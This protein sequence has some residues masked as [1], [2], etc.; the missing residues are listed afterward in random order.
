MDKKELLYIECI[1]AQSL[2][3][4]FETIEEMLRED[5]IDILCIC[6]TWLDS[7]LESKYIHIPKFNVTRSD[8]GRGAGVCI[9]S[10]E[11][12]KI[13][14]LDTGLDKIVNVED[15]WLQ[16]QHK[17]FSSFIVGCVYRHPK[18]LV[19]SFHYISN[20]FKNMCLNNKPIFILG[21]FNDNFFTKGNHLSKICKSLNLRQI[22]EK[23]T[24]ITQHSSTLLDLII[25][26]SVDM[27]M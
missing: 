21:D 23:P 20:V 7:S 27:I 16:V 17:K 3:C 11:S 26:N 5:E 24:R 10:R 18:A 2:L 6:E 19:E 14:V 15:V 4:H 13:K 12:L 25:T 8:A 22:V 9:Y 1:N